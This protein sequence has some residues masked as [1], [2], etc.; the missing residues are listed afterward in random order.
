MSKCPLLGS[1]SWEDLNTHLAKLQWSPARLSQAHAGEEELF[2][3]HSCLFSQ[4]ISNIATVVK[5]NGKGKILSCFES[6]T[7]KIRLY[8]C[9]YD[10]YNSGG[11]HN[12]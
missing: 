6:D 12:T 7:R 3:L 11:L 10:M 8:H 2:I 9:Y 1:E 4:Q 5:S